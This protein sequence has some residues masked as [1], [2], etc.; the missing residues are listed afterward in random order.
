[1]LR[2]NFKIYLGMINLIEGNVSFKTLRQTKVSTG[3]LNHLHPTSHKE[4][5]FPLLKY[6]DNWGRDHESDVD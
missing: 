6:R 2:E 3:F 1:M 4:E 5:V